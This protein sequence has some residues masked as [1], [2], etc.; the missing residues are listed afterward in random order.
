MSELKMF[1]MYE[2]GARHLII[3]E[4]EIQVVDLFAE[5]RGTVPDIKDFNIEEMS[6]DEEVALYEMSRYK[7]GEKVRVRRILGDVDKPEYFACSEF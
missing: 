6:E 5:Q 7:D 3:A 1:M 2:G 4:S